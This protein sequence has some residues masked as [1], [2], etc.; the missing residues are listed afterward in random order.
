MI[1]QVNKWRAINFF[2][3]NLK[4]FRSFAEIRPKSSSRDDDCS[5]YTFPMTSIAA[6]WRES[7]TRAR[8]EDEERAGE[9]AT[10]I[11]HHEDHI[12]IISNSDDDLV[13]LRLRVEPEK[14]F[15]DKFTDIE[16]YHRSAA[17]CCGDDDRKI[18]FT[19]DICH[20]YLMNG[21]K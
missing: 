10:L 7:I 17:G 13:D 9:F 19:V 18:L 5:V 1:A 8:E 4:F 11:S 21:P 6:A 12:E 14:T 3:F 16:S 2:I 15:S 20:G